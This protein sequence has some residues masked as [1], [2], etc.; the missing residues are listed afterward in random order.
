MNIDIPL[1]FRRIPEAR[2]L[3]GVS[4]IRD[5]AFCGPLRA[6]IDDEPVASELELLLFE[7]PNPHAAPALPDYSTWACLWRRPSSKGDFFGPMSP[8]DFVFLWNA[9]VEELDCCRPVLHCRITRPTVYLTDA[10]QPAEMAFDPDLAIFT[11][12]VFYPTSEP[13]PAHQPPKEL[14]PFL[15]RRLT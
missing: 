10:L 9:D 3:C 6:V 5:L 8:A 12:S 7:N 2:L 1:S 14:P 11:Q 13:A 4:T 15:R